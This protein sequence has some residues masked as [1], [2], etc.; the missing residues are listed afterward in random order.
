MTVLL[1][2]EAD[3][4]TRGTFCSTCD[5]AL[6][7]ADAYPVVFWGVVH[8]HTDLHFCRHC[9]PTLARG[10]LADF[11]AALDGECAV[12]QDRMTPPRRV[13]RLPTPFRHTRRHWRKRSGGSRPGR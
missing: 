13:E 12:Q 9:I 11:V 8:A 4:Y 10:L 2:D 7:T 1:A 3:G 5:R 6:D